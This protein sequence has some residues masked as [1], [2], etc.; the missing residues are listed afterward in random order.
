MVHEKSR[1]NQLV[2]DKSIPLKVFL[3]ETTY[4][5]EVLNVKPTIPLFPFVFKPGLQVSNGRQKDNINL[6]SYLPRFV[7]FVY[8]V[9]Y[10]GVT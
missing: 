10:A 8:L 9:F 3:E 4:K 6:W 5:Y 7:L 1:I 2:S